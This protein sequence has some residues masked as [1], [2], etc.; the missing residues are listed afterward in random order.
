MRS[1]RRHT[2]VYRCTECENRISLSFV[3]QHTS[4]TAPIC[5]VC[6]GSTK[7]VMS[8]STIEEE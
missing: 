2:V 8:G 6:G 5:G 7:L 3:S 1:I 4:I